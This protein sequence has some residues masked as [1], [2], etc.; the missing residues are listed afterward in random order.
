MDDLDGSSFEINAK[1]VIN[2]TGPYSDKI[3]K[4]DDPSVKELCVPSAGVLHPSQPL[5][6][7]C[8]APDAADAGA[9]HF[10]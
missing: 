4:I 5:T 3:R 8:P 7:S 1:S 2:A 9:R 10:S 6:C